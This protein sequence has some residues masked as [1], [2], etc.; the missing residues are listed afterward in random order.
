[1]HYLTKKILVV[2]LSISFIFFAITVVD[3]F[4]DINLF[5]QNGEMLDNYETINKAIVVYNQSNTSFR[6][7]N[8]NRKMSFYK[9]YEEEYAQVISLLESLSNEFRTNEKTQMYYRISMLLLNER[10]KMTQMYITYQSPTGSFSKDY[11]YIGLISNYITGFLNDLLS[12]YL[13]CINHLHSKAL[14]RFDRWQTTANVFML[15]LLFGLALT[16]EY[17]LRRFRRKMQDA[18]FVMKE[19][20]KRNFAIHDLE[21]T[22]YKDINEFIVTTNNMKH[23]IHELIQQI[24]AFSQQKIEHERQKRLLA[25]SRFKELQ[26]Q[27]NPHF[28]FNTLSMIIRQIQ[29]D[30]KETSIQLVK[31]TSL[32]LRNSLKNKDTTITIDEELELLRSYIFI[33]QLH[34]KNRIEIVLDLR[35]G[36]G[37]EAVYVPPLVIQPIVENAVIHGLKEIR[38]NGLIEINV[39]ECMDCFHATVT[40]NGIGMDKDQINSVFEERADHVGLHSV[41]QRL[42]LLYQREDVMD[43][44]SLPGKGTKVIMKFYKG[45]SRVCIPS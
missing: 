29:T 4:I 5:L 36:Y 42:K 16:L 28:L 2:F 37:G 25:E 33:Q 41:Y 6:L 45:V 32:L 34:L 8:R 30:K 10:H 15:L 40:D 20:G 23:E 26:V 27:I 7:Y 11:E 22:K 13:D 31:E 43:I 19:I 3:S 18:S 38:K 44:H 1:M 39:V 9:Q 21:L 17:V 35:R 24:E 12:A 14:A